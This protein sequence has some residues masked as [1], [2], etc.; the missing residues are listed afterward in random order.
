M[1]FILLMMQICQTFWSLNKVDLQ[2]SNIIANY[3]TARQ[4]NYKLYLVLVILRM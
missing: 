2:H 4:E 1:R 3:Q